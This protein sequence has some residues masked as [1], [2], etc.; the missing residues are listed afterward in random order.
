MVEIIEG[1][2]QFERSVLAPE[3]VA[4]VD[5]YA[6][7]CG[8][9][10]MM[11]PVIENLA[12]EYADRVNVVKVNIDKNERLAVLYNIMNIPTF[13]VFK[14]G[15]PVDMLVGVQSETEMKAMVDKYI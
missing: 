4:L 12:E 7:W 6:D 2:E 15:K 13:M 11:A 10:K 14:D 5:F 1:K 8:P 9:C 3:I